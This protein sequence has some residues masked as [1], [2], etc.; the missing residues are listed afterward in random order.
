MLPRLAKAGVLAG[1][2]Y[3][4]FFI[5]IG[6]PDDLARAQTLIPARMRRPAVFLDRDGVLNADSGYAHRPEQIEWT[7]DAHQAVKL[8]N[9]AGLFR[10]RRHQ[11]GGRRAWALRRGRRCAACIAG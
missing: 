2:S 7:A 8:F 4:G 11:S 6:I 3:D 9:D 10:L 1:K 5:D